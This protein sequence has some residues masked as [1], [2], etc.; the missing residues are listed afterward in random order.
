MLEKLVIKKGAF[1]DVTADVSIFRKL[2][3]INPAAE[4]VG[5]TGIRYQPD[6]QEQNW[7]SFTVLYPCASM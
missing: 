5:A 6:W 3:G 4:V 7:S 2:R 1:L